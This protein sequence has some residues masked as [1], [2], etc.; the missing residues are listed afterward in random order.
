[1]SC[2]VDLINSSSLVFSW[3][4]KSS[5]SFKYVLVLPHVEV[6][7]LFGSSVR[8]SRSPSYGGPTHN[9]LR[10]RHLGEHQSSLRPRTQLARFQKYPVANFTLNKF[11]I[12]SEG[13]NPTAST[14]SFNAL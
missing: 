3:A 9:Q 5:G 11:F 8:K 6:S 1:M 7:L 2:D 14:A 10:S 13:R 4:F 12:N